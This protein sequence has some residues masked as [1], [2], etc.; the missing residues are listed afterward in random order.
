ME[1]GRECYEVAMADRALKS[2]LKGKEEF[3]MK[4]SMEGGEKTDKA[5]ADDFDFD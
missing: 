5:R 1:L 4:Q 2:F 3:D